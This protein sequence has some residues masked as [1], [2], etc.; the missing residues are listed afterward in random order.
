MTDPLVGEVVAFAVVSALVGTVWTAAS[1][2]RRQHA[3]SEADR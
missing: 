1:V 3:E 2:H